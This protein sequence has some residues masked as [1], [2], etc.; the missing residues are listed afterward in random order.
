MC[1]CICIY[2]IYSKSISISISHPM[3]Y[4]GV[5]I[6]FPTIDNHS[7]REARISCPT[8]INQLFRGTELRN[9]AAG[10]EHGAR[11]VMTNQ[12]LFKPLET[13]GHCQ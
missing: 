10:R 11:Y 5:S 9:P 8:E 7:K 3:K 2:I 4:P 13:G 1:M 12:H 6:G